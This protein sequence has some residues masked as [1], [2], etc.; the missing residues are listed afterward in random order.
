MKIFLDIFIY[1]MAKR[2]KKKDNELKKLCCRG[3][4]GLS[5]S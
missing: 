1:P 2:I 3:A 4:I 5:D